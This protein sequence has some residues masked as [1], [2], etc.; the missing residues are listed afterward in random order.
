MNLLQ[1]VGAHDPDETYPGKATLELCQGIRRP[2]RAEQR[3]HGADLQPGVA[4]DALGAGEA[5]VQGRHVRRVLQRVLRADQQPDFVQLQAPHGL[6]SNVRMPAVRRIEGATQ[7]ADMG[8][9]LWQMP[10]QRLRQRGWSRPRGQ[11]RAALQHE[12]GRLRRGSRRSCA[13]G[14]CSW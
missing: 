2:A 4:R 10:A 14:T 11:A 3:F 12:I 6:Q 9:P 8:A 5:L 7:Q 1:V 13:R